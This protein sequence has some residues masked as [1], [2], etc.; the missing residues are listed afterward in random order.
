VR[1]NLSNLKGGE[2]ERGEMENFS[3]DG[4][5]PYF[6][7]IIL[8]FL[9]GDKEPPG[10]NKGEISQKKGKEKKGARETFRQPT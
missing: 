10:E 2:E 8:S 5:N 6:P 7:L 3:T 1:D 4:V 9:H